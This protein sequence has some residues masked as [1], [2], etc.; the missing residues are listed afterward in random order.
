M[1]DKICYARH[2]SPVFI[3]DAHIQK[4]YV[5]IKHFIKILI[6]NRL[7]SEHGAGMVQKR[8]RKKSEGENQKAACSSQQNPFIVYWLASST[9]PDTLCVCA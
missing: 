2:I 4:Y 3:N 1:T 9:A 6:L 5:N 7:L 8:T